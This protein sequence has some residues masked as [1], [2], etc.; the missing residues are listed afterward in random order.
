MPKYRK[1]WVRTIDS[2]DMDALP[3]DTARLMVLYLIL[4]LDRYGLGIDSPTWIRSKCF[5]LRDDVSLEKITEYMNVC[6]HLKIITR[7]QVGERK[8]FYLTNFGQYQ[9]DTSRESESVLPLPL[10]WS[11]P[12][13]QEESQSEPGKEEVKPNSGVGLEEVKPNSAPYTYTDSN[14]NTDTD[15]GIYSAPASENELV[16]HFEA[17]YGKQTEVQHTLLLEMCRQF[18][19]EH[20]RAA[21]DWAMGKNMPAAKAL[22]SMS[23]ALP[24]WVDSPPKEARKRP[25]PSKMQKN[26]DAVRKFQERLQNGNT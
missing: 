23:T 15:T 16:T 4:V 14:T 8:Y 13:A 10:E 7:Y 12:P 21:M 3:D 24:G 18:G 1:V 11:T 20:T 22:S 25:K 6:E 9:G 2:P 26:I 17:L 5:P 19:A